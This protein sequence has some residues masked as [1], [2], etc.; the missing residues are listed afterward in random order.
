MTVCKACRSVERWLNTWEPL[1]QLAA[2]TAAT[3]EAVAVGGILITPN[4]NT[5]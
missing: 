4:P 5:T 1:V 2:C 3:G